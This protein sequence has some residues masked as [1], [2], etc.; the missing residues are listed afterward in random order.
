MKERLV[1]CWNC[2]T[3]ID[4]NECKD[5]DHF[6]KFKPTKVCPYCDTCL[7]IHPDFEKLKFVKDRYGYHVGTLFKAEEIK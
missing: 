1:K 7:C 2:K 5:C 6:G 3:L 4:L